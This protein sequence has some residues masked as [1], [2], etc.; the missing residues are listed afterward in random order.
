M[1]APIAE[2][3]LN[4]PLRQTFDYLIPE[5][6]GSAVAPGCRVVVPFGARLKSGIVVALKAAAD[7]A[8]ER[9]KAVQRA[10]EGAPLF[11]AE[12]LRFT[13][14]VADYYLCGWGEV[15]EAALPQ[16]MAAKIAARFRLR[17]HPPPAETLAGLSQA[18]RALLAQHAEWSLGQWRRS[19]RGESDARWLWRQARPGGVVAVEYEYAGTR[20]RPRTEVWVKLGPREPAPARARRNPLKETVQERVLR[21]L[22]EEGP[23]PMARLKSQVVHPSPAVKRLEGEGALV[24]YEQPVARLPHAGTPVRPEP[25]LAPTPEQAAAMEAVRAALGSGRYRGFL[26]EGVT[27]SGKTEV[28]L[29]AVR[30]TLAAGRSAL[31]LVPEIALTAS[32]VGR[33][34]ARFGEAVAVLHSGMSEGE[35]FDE[36]NRVHAGRARIVIGAR[37]AVFA[38]LADLGL[39]VVDE[40]HDTSYKQDEAPRYNGR[41]AALMRAHQNGAVALLG[42]ATPSM[43]AAHNAGVGKLTRLTLPSRIQARALPAV[44]LLDLRTVPRQPGCAFFSLP[45][46][47]ALRETLRRR[48]QALV[49]LNRRGF[50]QLL[51]CGACGEPVTC[52]NC[53][54]ALTYHQTERRLRC[55]RCDHSQPRPTQCPACAAAALDVLGLG[56]Q[57]LEQDLALMFPA[58]RILRMDS[59]SLRRRGELERMLEGIRDHRFDLVIGTQVLSKGHDFPKIT[60][61]GAVLGDVSLNMPDFR[62]PERTFQLLTQMA[63]RAGRGERPGRVLI[64]TYN[65][66][67]YAFAHV[68]SHDTAGFTAAE[69]PIRQGAQSPPYAHL[70]LV[71]ASS[72][73]AG[74]AARLAEALGQ[75]LREAIA[76]PAAT[77]PAAPAPTLLGPAEAPIRKLAGRYRWMLG[78]SAETIGPIHRTLRA[79][80]DDPALKLGAQER[81]AVDVDPYNLM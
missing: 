3:A 38:P 51:R 10:P 43:E 45:L 68:R 23:V 41:D 44:E 19:A 80:L 15:L 29:H 70:A 35:R 54:L 73:D 63:G 30:E 58:A 71:W 32:M 46:V 17:A 14:W 5:A 53:S 13:R 4:L 2:V 42:S 36:W 11:S 26:L 81:L 78:L 12:L 37:S 69:L 79:A 56:T 77:G 49:F 24:R 25:F 76:R 57:R 52:P 48:E 47:E 20:Q 1:S 27:G 8:P 18:A 33:F 6:L 64:Q 7:V 28:Y 22:R 65:P 40:E 55:H 62:A 74:R 75:R 16:G 39:V 34:R 67:H 66:Q 72:P 9:L 61:V 59:D 31:V 21:V 50:A 60:L